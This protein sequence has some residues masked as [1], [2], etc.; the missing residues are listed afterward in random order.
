MHRF[1]VAHTY[2]TYSLVLASCFSFTNQHLDVS[3]IHHKRGSKICACPELLMLYP[4]LR[5]PDL[6][7]LRKPPPLVVFV[8]IRRE[9]RL[10]VHGVRH[11]WPHVLAV[12]AGMVVMWLLMSIARL[13]TS[14]VNLMW[15]PKFYT[16]PPYLCPALVLYFYGFSHCLFLCANRNMNLANREPPVVLCLLWR[17]ILYGGLP[18]HKVAPACMPMHC[19][20]PLLFHCIFLVLDQPLS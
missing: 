11:H 20:L 2:T 9:C 12:C 5:P 3:G 19:S 1:S 16:T 14:V 8:E 6:H 10:I 15:C 18:N 4:H 17:T 7:A 13:C